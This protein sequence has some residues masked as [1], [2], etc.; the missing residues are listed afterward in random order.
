MTIVSL[1][2]FATNAVR[3][4]PEPVG[5]GL[6]HVIGQLHGRSNAAG[7]RQLRANLDRIVPVGERESR[8]RG[9]RSMALYMRY[10]YEAFRLPSLT[11]EQIDA[12]VATENLDQLRQV[13][14]DYGSCSGALM[15]MGNWDLAGAWATRNLAP[16]HTIAEKLKPD[17]LADFF[18]SFRRNLGMTIY[19]AVKGAGS[20]SSIATDMSRGNV[21]A[22]L[23][24]D[25]DLSATGVVVH[26]CGHDIKVAPGAALLA[27]K[28][29]T[30]MVPVTILADEFPDDADRVK[31]AG[32]RYGVRLMIGAPI[33]P[34]ANEADSAEL[35][36]ADVERM[37]QEWMDQLGRVM[38]DA[39][40]H[41]HMLQKVFVADLDRERR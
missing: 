13:L 18:L 28:T 15:H 20:I 12:R 2:K 31:R 21:F 26:L 30:P 29:G 25:R 17:E 4:I 9:G 39:I 16:V 32:T 41:W 19:Q 27:H 3:V 34:R 37:L 40:E 6:F 23:L 22:P 11:G 35:R 10:Y 33:Y 1:F 24:S 14:R 8:R 7:A 36:Q 38:P 5:R